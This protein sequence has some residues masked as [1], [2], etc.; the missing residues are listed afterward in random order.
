MLITGRSPC[1]GMPPQYMIGAC[2]RAL[3]P[4]Q[5]QP[6]PGGGEEGKEPVGGAGGGGGERGGAEVAPEPRRGQPRRQLVHI[7]SHLC[8][9]L[10]LEGG[11]T[12]GGEGKGR[13]RMG[14]PR[15]DLAEAAEDVGHGGAEAGELVLLVRQPPLQRVH[16]RPQT[17][18][19][20]HQHLI[21]NPPLLLH[22]HQ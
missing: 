4:G 9:R 12:G 3:D 15:L 13:T 5:L 16:A 14:R 22:S 17:R 7:P 8:R 11:R 1:I 19:L 6:S 20:T 10:Y 21:F 18:V 2:W